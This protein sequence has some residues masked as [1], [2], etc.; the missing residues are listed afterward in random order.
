LVDHLAET[1]VHALSVVP[2]F[3]LG[4]VYSFDFGLSTL[5][6]VNQGFSPPTPGQVDAAPERALNSELGLRFAK[7]GLKLE[8][9]GFWSEYQNL[10]G[11]C[12]DSSGCTNDAINRQFNGG[13]ARVLG[14]EAL[15]SV[16][17]KAGWGVTAIG[18]LHYTFTS[19]HF[20]TD[21]Q[22]D[23]PSW[24]NV[25]AQAELP[26]VP[27]HQG[28]LR[29]RGSKGP[30]ELGLGAMYYGAIR[31][32]AGVGSIDPAVLVPGRVLVDATAAIEWGQA[33]LY[34][35]ATNLINS[36]ALVSR[37]PFGARPQAPM[38]IQVGFKYSFR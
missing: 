19:A 16:R 8:A 37:R 18:E 36:S 17:F 33:R 9:V 32:L 7:H 10:T 23:N 11:E 14:V 22:S 21:F 3:G 30:F 34:V 38:L 12:T 6:G 35:T 13:A 24:G 1:S 2:L 28:R 25:V 4:A 15:G 27:R 31:E 20:L 29:L 5:A 26:Y